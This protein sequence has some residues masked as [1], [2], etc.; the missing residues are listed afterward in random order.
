[1]FIYLWKKACE[2]VQDVHHVQKYTEYHNNNIL[3]CFGYFDILLSN[4]KGNF[5]VNLENWRMYE[6][7]V[8][9]FQQEFRKIDKTLR[10]FFLPFPSLFEEETE[11]VKR[12]RKEI[13][14]QPSSI[15]TSWNFLKFHGI[16]LK[17]GWGIGRRGQ[18]EKKRSFRAAAAPG[19]LTVLR[20]I[21]LS[22]GILRVALP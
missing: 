19:I 22:S 10:N 8:I 12:R 5:V 16:N 4:G 1:M 6:R 3:C 2:C 15:F 20:G 9:N 11:E 14:M 7:N 13:A 21:N 18:E 17:L